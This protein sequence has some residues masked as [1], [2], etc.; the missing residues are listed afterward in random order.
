[1][2]WEANEAEGVIVFE[3]ESCDRV[4]RVNVQETRDTAEKPEPN[5]TDFIMCWR[6]QMGVGW[7][8][9]KRTGRNWSYHCPACGAQAEQDHRDFQSQERERER[10][11]ARNAL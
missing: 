8:S 1:M 7:R 4:D 10:L 6:R 9:F 11:K 5:T 3:C 2:A